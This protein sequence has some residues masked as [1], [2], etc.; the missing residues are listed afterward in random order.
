MT[1]RKPREEMTTE[2]LRQA[3]I[4][5]C[6]KVL[7][8]MKETIEQGLETAPEHLLKQ[9]DAFIIL[10]GALNALEF[11]YLELVASGKVGNDVKLP[12]TTKKFYN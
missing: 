2:E 8:L 4:A 9:G 10:A 6:N 3:L 7:E 12:E 1:T 11:R 5:D